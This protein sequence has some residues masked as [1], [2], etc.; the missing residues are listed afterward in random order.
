MVSMPSVPQNSQVFQSP[1]LSSLPHI[2][3]EFNVSLE[4]STCDIANPHTTILYPRVTAV[5]TTPYHRYTPSSPSLL[6]PTAVKAKQVAPSRNPGLDHP[7]ENRLHAPQALLPSRCP[8][9]SPLLSRL[10]LSLLLPVEWGPRG[11]C[12]TDIR[13]GVPSRASCQGDIAPCARWFLQ[14]G[15]GECGYEVERGGWCSRR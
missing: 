4:H 12:H 6:P 15:C 2:H 9:L 8:P 14:V 5:L 13:S 11:E 1:C 7:A 10:L 3:R